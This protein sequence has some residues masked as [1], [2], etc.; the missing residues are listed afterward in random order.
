MTRVPLPGRRSAFTLIEL[1]VVIAIIAILIGL[2]LPAV[3]KVREAAARAKC[4]NNLKQIGLAIHNH[5]STYQNVPAWGLDFNPAPTPNPYGPQ[6]Q[7]HAAFTYLLEFIEQGN[8][9]TGLNRQHSVIDPINL[10]APIGTSTAG[11][12]KISVYYCPS[13]PRDDPTADYGPYFT[14]NGLP[15]GGPLLLGATDYA[16]VRGV[17]DTFVNACATTSPA[18]SGDKGMLGSDDIKARPKVKFSATTDGLSNTV[19]VTELAGRQSIYWNGKKTG[20]LTL[21]AA[22]ADYNTARRMYG[23]NTGVTYP[24]VSGTGYIGSPPTAIQGCQMINAQNDYG[25]YSFHS[26]GVNMLMGDGSV[27]FTQ[28]TTAPGVLAAMITR[29]GGEVLQSN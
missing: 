16:V 22:W 9:V 24:P 19:C 26:G 1:L 21:N 17:H 13:T 4:A 20:W 18:G 2:L 8:L 11:L 25:M 5:E 10:P 28:Q 27:R 7:G 3:Q 29:D 14:A 12:T 23:F 15:T 6:T